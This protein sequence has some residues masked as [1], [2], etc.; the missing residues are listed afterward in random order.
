MEDD[1][2]KIGFYLGLLLAAGIAQA[3]MPV[4][5]NAVC[6]S[7]VEK[8]RGDLLKWIQSGKA[9]RLTLPNTLTADGYKTKM[10]DQITH[11]QITCVQEYL[12]VNGQ[13]QNCKVTGA[14]QAQCTSEPL[15]NDTGEDRQYGWVHHEYAELAGIEAGPGFSDTSPISTQLMRFLKPTTDLTLGADLQ[16]LPTTQNVVENF[17]DFFGDY[18]FVSCTYYSSK[19][20]IEKPCTTQNGLVLD[21]SNTRL[22]MEMLEGTL[23][24]EY[25]NLHNQELMIYQTAAYPDASAGDS[26]YTFYGEQS[27]QGIGSSGVYTSRVNLRNANGL[28][29]LTNDMFESGATSGD[30]HQVYVLRKIS[31]P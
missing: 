14:G 15:I 26:C 25:R 9:A 31:V 7:R 19:S 18:E 1:A 21:P 5:D 16:P 6:Q 28:T 17:K 10:L 12:K 4:I 2:M 23:Q 3:A 13:D 29:Y 27:C 11:S 20:P 24:I 8:I 22:K 30:L